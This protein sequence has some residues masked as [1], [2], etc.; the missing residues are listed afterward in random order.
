MSLWLPGSEG[1]IREFGIDMYTL[2]YLKY[3]NRQV[4]TVKKR[5]QENDTDENKMGE[6]CRY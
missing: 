6:R 5:G 3:Y 2:L 4:P 1:I